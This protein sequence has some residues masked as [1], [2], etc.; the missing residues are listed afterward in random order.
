MSLSLPIGIVMALAINL[1]IGIYFF[2]LYK[3]QR[4]HQCYLYWACSCALFAVGIAVAVSAH[5]AGGMQALNA[6]ACL[7]LFG[8]AYGLFCGLNA[9]ELTRSSSRLFKKAQ[10]LFFV[11]ALAILVASLFGQ[12]VNAIASACMAIMFLITEGFFYHRRSPYQ[13]AYAALRAILL[14]HA[15]IL[16]LQSAVIAVMLAS[17]SDAGM[18]QLFDVTLLTHLVLTVATALLLPILHVSRQRRH[19]QKLACYDG[20]TGLLSRRTF[21]QRAYQSITDGNT[22]KHALLMVDI[23]HFKKIN[24]RHGHQC[25]DEVLRQIAKTLKGSI[26][27]TDIIG[28]LGGEEFAILMPGLS[29]ERAQDVANRMLQS[30]AD[31]EICY[32][33]HAIQATVSIGISAS[34]D[35]FDTWDTLLENADK[36]LYG[37]KR[38][39]RNLVFIF[40]QALHPQGI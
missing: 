4:K 22:E 35:I 21:I 5:S 32:E 2:A 18:L 34:T 20:L 16:F 11:G 15:F 17:G 40:G 14:L 23:D 26:R 36:A 12:A 13:T 30:V 24:D 37:A 3:E 29:A 10:L 6:V 38:K 9:F 8:A 25:G 7:L 1:L 31:S 33:G 27:E 39:G 19:W 28:R